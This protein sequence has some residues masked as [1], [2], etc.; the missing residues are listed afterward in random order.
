MN[1]YQKK[2]LD[3][4]LFYKGS[5]VSNIG[6]VFLVNSE[7][8]IEVFE[9]S[10]NI[11]INNTSGLHLRLNREMELYSYVEEYKVNREIVNFNYEQVVD[12]AN[13]WTEVPFE[14]LFD[15][16]LFDIKI[17]QFRGG[18]VVYTKMH[19]LLGDALSIYATSREVFRIY[20]QIME[21]KSINVS[22]ISA[23][24]A[25]I[26]DRLKCEAKEYFKIKLEDFS[27]S[28]L[29]E[30]ESLEYKANRQK[31][32]VAVD[33]SKEANID[34]LLSLYTYLLNVTDAD[35]IAIGYVLA[36]RRKQDIDKF[37]MYANTLPIILERASDS[38][39]ELKNTIKKE[40]LSLIKYSAYSLEGE[41]DF[42]K[43]HNNI[44]DV[45]VSYIRES[46][47]PQKEI[48][49][50]EECFN[51][52][53]DVPIRI[54][55]LES[56]NKL[57]FAICYKQ[58]LFEDDYINNMGKA[59]TDI[60]TKVN[61]VSS[62]NEI[63]ILTSTDIS[64]YKKINNTHFVNKYDDIVDAIEYNLNEN[65]AIIWKDGKVDGLKFKSDCKKIAAFI[66][67]VGAK[68]IGIK[69][70]RSYQ[71][72]VAAVGALY[73]G[74]AFMVVSDKIAGM[75]DYCDYIVDKELVDN[76]KDYK[77]RKMIYDPNSTAYMICTS[78]TTGKPKC[79]EI[80]RKSLLNRLE[81]ADSQ[82]SFKGNILQKT[83]NT[84][85]VSIWEM[86]SVSFGARLCLLEDGE[87]KMP[88]KIVQA[89]TRFDIEK[90]H[91]VPSM[92]KRF[93]QYI[94]LNGYSL[95]SLKEIYT[96]GEKLDAKLVKDFFGIFPEK[97]LI[98]LYGPAECTIDVTHFECQREVD[99]SDIPIGI[100]VGNTEI[101]ILNKKNKILPIG[102]KGEI[103]VKGILVGKGYLGKKEKNNEG[104]CYVNNE[105]VYK[106]GDIGKIGFDGQ[107]YIY[108][109]RDNQ[110]KIRG[111]RIDLSEIKNWILEEDEIIDAQVIK[112]KNRIECYYM[113]NLD[114][115]EIRKKIAANISVFAVPSVFY[116]VDSFNYT[117]NGKIDNKSL[118]NKINWVS[119]NVLEVKNSDVEEEIIKLIE[120]CIGI[121]VRRNENIFDSG[122][123][124]LSVI[125][126]THKLQQRGYPI[127]YSDF[128]ENLT[129]CNIAKNIGENHL[130]SF[131]KKG[132]KEKLLLCFTCA[133]GNPQEYIK[134]IEGVECDVAVV[135]NSKFN[136]KESVVTIVDKISNCG[137]FDEY[138][139]AYVLGHC[140]GSS[141]AIE[142]ANRVNEKV[143]GVILLAPSVNE[144]ELIPFWKYMPDKVIWAILRV[145]GNKGKYNRASITQFVKD[146]NRVFSHVALSPQKKAGYNIDVVYGT[147]DIFTINSR[148][149][150]KRLKKSTK[151]EVIEHTIKN[152]K[153]YFNKY[154]SEEVAKIINE[155]IQRH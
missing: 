105:R 52:C 19:H 16:R 15:S 67:A 34:F 32:S 78:G 151:G 69:I 86:M 63:S 141:I 112:N 103:C 12:M 72:M 89:I 48:G 38:I 24:Y 47:L 66:Q 134:M 115:D 153:H 71:M 33:G 144:K 125:D 98:N 21:E 84:F 135:Y 121:R 140:V 133:G 94:K 81:W 127:D 36:N 3:A 44:F 149:I 128:Y 139:Y 114:I 49:E 82:Y 56:D 145:A 73:A 58:K 129:V 108:G 102:V 31:F 7:I 99:Y 76:L 45:S 55:V 123:D 54:V 155:V 30:K 96:S 137:L 119:E 9:E 90:I 39:S 77:F 124:S 40:V 136:E 28:K 106:T 51:G 148:K 132:S 70:T 20:K 41:K 97:R 17:V 109:R 116:N 122:I 14:S 22:D 101:V 57:E 104:F 10:L 25:E 46:L 80:S 85:D 107:I 37:G 88:D 120:E 100:P 152:A 29:S 13:K 65:D 6:G 18:N 4:D 147:K 1:D 117:T 2:I 8:D 118:C 154:N 92:L 110:V 26:S 126:I 146:T 138:K 60:F 75:E 113:G 5:S 68:R 23:E 62:I 43:V 95:P 61:T 79:I 150:T 143:E 87:E 111:I 131:L 130:F 74:S 64:I 50:I 142:L 59:I 91:F 11:F 42:E 53:L 93:L 27:P 83:V 35:K